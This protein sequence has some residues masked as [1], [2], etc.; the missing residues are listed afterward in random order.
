MSIRYLY[1]LNKG[2]QLCKT[3]LKG[4]HLYHTYDVMMY[5]HVEKCFSKVPTGDFFY[6]KCNTKQSCFYKTRFQVPLA[7]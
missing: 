2:K 7:E 5:V 3:C 4:K 1:L 6:F